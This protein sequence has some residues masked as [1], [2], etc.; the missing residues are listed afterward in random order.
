MENVLNVIFIVDVFN[1]SLFKVCFVKN[2]EEG[3]FVK[4]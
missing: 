3:E 2:Y 4:D 1:L